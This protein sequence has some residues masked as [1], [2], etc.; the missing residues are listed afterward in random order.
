MSSPS[1][2]KLFAGQEP[3]TKTHDDMLL[4]FEE[5]KKTIVEK[6]LNRFGFLYTTKKITILNYEDG[7]RQAFKTP[8]KI[9]EDGNETLGSWEAFVCKI[10]NCSYRRM[11]LEGQCS[12]GGELI[13]SYVKQ[14]H[15]KRYYLDE[16]QKRYIVN[17]K[18]KTLKYKNTIKIIKTEPERCILNNKYYIG[19]V[20]LFLTVRNDKIDVEIDDGWVWKDFDNRFMEKEIIIEFKPTIKSFSEVLRQINVYKKY[21]SGALAV[22]IT[23]SD[24]SRFKKIFEENNILLIHAG[25]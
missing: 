10:C 16:N 11:P 15:S 7:H 8:P 25:E 9:E 2:P 6:I 5:N 23:Y 1:K 22:V 18:T 21:L 19:S 14:E 12:C 20:D 17:E 13:I 4:W 24:C 3:R